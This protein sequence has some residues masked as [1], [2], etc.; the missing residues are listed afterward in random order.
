MRCGRQHLNALEFDV[1]ASIDATLLALARGTSNS[2]I[3]ARIVDHACATVNAVSAK[4]TDMFTQADWSPNSDL[5]NDQAVDACGYIA[6]DAV[7][8]LREAALAGTNR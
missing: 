6:T 1:D 8:R 7:Y 2:R 3:I 5:F 4:L